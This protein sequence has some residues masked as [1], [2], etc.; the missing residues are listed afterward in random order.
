MP[1]LLFHKSKPK[2]S[3]LTPSSMMLKPYQ[4][5]HQSVDSRGTPTI[6]LL[7]NSSS[8]MLLRTMSRVIRSFL[9]RIAG[10]AAQIA[11]SQRY[12]WLRI[13]SMIN[14]SPVN[15]FA[16]ETFLGGLMHY[17]KEGY[18]GAGATVSDRATSERTFLLT[19]NIPAPLEELA[20][21]LFGHSTDR[22]ISEKGSVNQARVFKT[23]YRHL[24]VLD[25]VQTQ[26]WWKGRRYCAFRKMDMAPA[27]TQWR[28]CTRCERVTEDVGQSQNVPIWLQR[29]WRSCPCGN[30]FLSVEG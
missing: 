11:P 2:V 20:K 18:D 28:R 22:L 8:R 7:L 6:C 1:T 14:D 13:I 12:W 9:D 27:M 16:F 3:A 23:D 19:G 30:G 25:D 15:I 5:P 17:A 21:R 10:I 26:R 4:Q 29:L 24:N